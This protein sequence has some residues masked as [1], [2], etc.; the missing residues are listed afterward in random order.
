VAGSLAPG[1]R[2]TIPGGSKAGR[3]L[4]CDLEREAWTCGFSKERRVQGG[5]A[6]LTKPRRQ[7]PDE[8]PVSILIPAYKSAHFAASLD[9]A[10]AQT[11]PRGEIIVADDSPD[12]AIAEMVEAARANVRSGWTLRYHR[13]PGTIGGRRNYL[14]LFE[15][16]GGPL[17][18]YLNDDDLLDPRCVERM[19]RALIEHPDATLVTSYRRLIDGQGAALPDKPFNEPILDEDAVADGRRLANLVLSTGVNRIGEPTTVMFRKSDVVDNTPHLMSYAGRSARR[20]GD[21]TTWIA[22]LSRGDGIWLREPLSSFRLHDG[23][24][25]RDETFRSEAK[26]AW[27]ELRADGDETGLIAPALEDLAPRPLADGATV[28]ETLR[29]AAA[30]LDAQ[31]WDGVR[32]YLEMA[33]ACDARHWAARGNLARL[34]W[35]NG[36][37]ENAVLGAALALGGQADPELASDLKAMLLEMGMAP[38]TAAA[39]EAEACGSAHA[40]S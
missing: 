31:D 39:I 32:H 8:P 16:A 36:D 38:A 11:W 22:L 20:N 27:K 25:Q 33:L 35:R 29:D 5:F 15:M 3:Y 6:M 19:A 26:L 12:G 40:R 13:N 1:G 9:S 4:R 34:A 21:V 30:A 10:L 37:R 14:Q 24:V 23:Q 2:L 7:L 28:A 17:V 18:K